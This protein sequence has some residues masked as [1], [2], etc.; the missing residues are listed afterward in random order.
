LQELVSTR[1]ELSIDDYDEDRENSN[2]LQQSFLAA[3]LSYNNGYASTVMANILQNIDRKAAFM[4]K[5]EQTNK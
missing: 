3:S 2:S 1:K 5:F 4:S